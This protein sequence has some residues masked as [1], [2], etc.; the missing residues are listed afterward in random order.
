MFA[1]VELRTALWC[2][3]R[4][5]FPLGEILKAENVSVLKQAILDKLFKIV[6]GFIP[7]PINSTSSNMT[8]TICYLMAIQG[9][10]ME[11]TMLPLL[12]PQEKI[13]F[14]PRL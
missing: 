7:K 4:V 9:W 5:P 2:V 11:L 3:V 13:K 6:N 12:A 10:P 1:G 14:I 8:S